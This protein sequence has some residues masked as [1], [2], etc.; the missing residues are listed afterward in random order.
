M[1]KETPLSADDSSSLQRRGYRSI[2]NNGPGQS[3]RIFHHRSQ[4]REKELRHPIEHNQRMLKD[5]G[6]RTRSI[7]QTEGDDAHGGRGDKRG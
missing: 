3:G 5:I 6:E 2:V 1:R 7:S 4:M